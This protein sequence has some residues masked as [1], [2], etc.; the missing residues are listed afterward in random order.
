LARGTILLK[1]PAE[2]TVCLIQRVD[3]P[4]PIDSPKIL[5][6]VDGPFHDNKI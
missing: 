3:K 4:E 1:N 5:I 2:G 6:G